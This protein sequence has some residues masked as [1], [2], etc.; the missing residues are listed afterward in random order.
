MSASER[1]MKKSICGEEARAIPMASSS[2]SIIEGAPHPT[3]RRLIMWSRFSVSA[4]RRTSGCARIS[5]CSKKICE[6]AQSACRSLGTVRWAKE[7]WA[8]MRTPRETWP[9]ADPGG[10]TGGARGGQTRLSLRRP[11]N[12]ELHASYAREPAGAGCPSWSTR[13]SAAAAIRRASTVGQ[14]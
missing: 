1:L 13:R 8:M 11:S 9:S 14:K 5:R 12:A 3:A 6:G 7:R 2:T 10:E 4:H